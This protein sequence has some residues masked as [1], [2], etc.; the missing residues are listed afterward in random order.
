MHTLLFILSFLLTV[1]LIYIVDLKY[2]IMKE[3]LYGLGSSV[4][5]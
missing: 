5:N 2:L 4:I 1:N 3:K